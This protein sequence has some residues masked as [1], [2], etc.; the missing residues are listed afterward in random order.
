MAKGQAKVDGHLLPEDDLNGKTGEYAR[1]HGQD[2][3]EVDALACCGPVERIVR[4][5]GGHWVEND[6]LLRGACLSIVSVGDQQERAGWMTLIL[7]A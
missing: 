6:T 3:G 4:V 2:Q 5:C 7:S 1:S